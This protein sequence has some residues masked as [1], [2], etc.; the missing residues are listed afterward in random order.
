MVT[1]VAGDSGYEKYILVL[2]VNCMHKRPEPKSYLSTDNPQN[3]CER[4]TT[5]AFQKYDAFVVILMQM[6]SGY[7]IHKMRLWMTGK[8]LLW[9]SYAINKIYNT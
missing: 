3:V 1:L 2:E 9:L 7:Y 6:F 8:L 4:V 5:T